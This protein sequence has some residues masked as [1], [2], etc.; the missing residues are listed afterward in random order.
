[1]RN[2]IKATSWLAGASALALTCAASSAA[3]SA[4]TAAGVIAEPAGQVEEVIVTAQKREERS[5]TVP[6]AIATISSKQ[7]AAQGIT[8]TAD[9]SAAVPGL[10][11]NR[12][13]NSATPFIRG[14]GNPAGSAGEE[15]ATAVYIDG[16]YNPNQF[17]NLFELNSIERVEVLKGPQGTLFGRNSAAGAILVTTKTP[18]HDFGLNASVG[19]GNYNTVDAG[20]Y[21]TGGITDNLAANLALQGS[22]QGSP[23]GHD[24]TTGGPNG[25]SNYFSARTKFLWT[26]TDDTKVTLSGDYYRQKEYLV[27]HTINLNAFGYNNPGFYNSLNDLTQYTDVTN[28]GASVRVEHDFK[29]FTFVSISSHRYTTSYDMYDFDALPLN[30]VAFTPLVP[31][32][33]SWTQEFQLLSEPSSPIKWVAGFFYFHDRAGFDPY[34][35]T[36]TATGVATPGTGPAYFDRHDFQITDSFAGF[37]QATAPLDFL[38][39]DTH[40]TAG[41]RYSVDERTLELTQTSNVPAL[42]LGTVPDRNVSYPKATWRV[43]LDHQFSPDVMAYVSFNTGFKSGLYNLNAPTDAPVR[44]ETITA[45]EA[46]IKARILDG[47]LQIEGSFF[48]YDFRDI[49]L[50]KVNA[51]GG[52]SLLNAAAAEMYGLDLSFTAVPVTNLTV[53]GAVELL[54]SRFTSFPNAPFTYPKPATCATGTTG[55]PTGGNIACFLDATGNQMIQAPPFTANLSAN[56]TVPLSQGA[57]L[58]SGAYSYNSGFFWEPDNRLKQPAFSNLNASIGWRSPSEKWEVRLWGQNLTNTQRSALTTSSTSGD[59]A[60]PAPP[61][62]YGVTLSMKMGG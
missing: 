18:S 15:G 48:H 13:I 27:G 17:A 19:Y 42:N 58:L 62:T 53:S 1:V 39:K 45:E 16:V 47:R 26:P 61:R 44:P 8:S 38:W 10:Q 54:N 33:S 43:S 24:L 11:M 23:W 31:K 14:V 50:R 49:Q 56:Y 2:T 28:Y 29:K 36:G 7:L 20:I 5:L 25:T 32:D 40:L 22:H 52:T 37:A 41:A 51:T 34:H 35:Q 55:T 30:Q 6:I 46:G 9:L 3:W 21:V 12:S 60:L 59:G 57:L 4:E